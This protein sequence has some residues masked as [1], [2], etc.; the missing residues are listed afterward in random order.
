VN[1][2]RALKGRLAFD[3][4]RLR[5]HDI[6]FVPKTSLAKADQFMTHIY[7][8]LPRQV[9]LSFEYEIHNEPLDVELR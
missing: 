9:F 3:D 2:K 6:V 8:F 4:Y 5:A 7:N 1:L